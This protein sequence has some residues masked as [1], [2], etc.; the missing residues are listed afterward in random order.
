MAK[1]NKRTAD[2]GYH[3]TDFCRSRRKIS[4]MAVKNPFRT[5]LIAPC[6]MNC[7]ICMAY[8]R[9]KNHCSGCRTTDRKC[10]INCAIS[11]CEKV[12]GKFCSP[13]CDEY[14]C[15]R[16]RHLDERY[17]KK[18]GMSMM[19]NLEAIRRDGIRA[20]VKTERER[21]TCQECG[22]TINVHRWKC[23]E[24]GKERE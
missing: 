20:F 22:G 15:K 11:A 9:E 24:C 14:P 10:H 13:G 7:A 4:S 18:Y 8:L 3:P 19:E 2:S 6:G 23:S 5:T 1:V 16:L 12:Q 21:W 17:R